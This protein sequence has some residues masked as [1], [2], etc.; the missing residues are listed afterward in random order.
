MTDD[1]IDVTEL[2][3]L[4]FPDGK[5]VDEMTRQDFDRLSATT[6]TLVDK[7]GEDQ[8]AAMLNELTTMIGGQIRA[9][10]DLTRPDL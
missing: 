8:I 5:R 2:E 9:R 4:L 10:L 6:A 7:Y 3:A 1:H